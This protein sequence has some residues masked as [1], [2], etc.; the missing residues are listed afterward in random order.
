MR[1]IA[2][3]DDFFQMAI[4][5]LYDLVSSIAMEYEITRPTQLFAG[6]CFH[7]SHIPSSQTAHPDRLGLRVRTRLPSHTGRLVSGSAHPSAG[8]CTDLLRLTVSY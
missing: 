3:C 6:H 2:L 7:K 1:L 5:R 4:L 8:R